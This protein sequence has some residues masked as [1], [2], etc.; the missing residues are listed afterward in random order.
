MIRRSPNNTHKTSL[1]ADLGGFFFENI[2]K[3]GF[4]NFLVAIT[5]SAKKTTK[6]YL[7]FGPEM[8]ISAVPVRIF[9]F[10]GPKKG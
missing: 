6:I 1:N 3:M 9:D 2:L 10:S 4:V 5:R 7:F 8:R